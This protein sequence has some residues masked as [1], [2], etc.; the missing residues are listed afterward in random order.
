MSLE[1]RRVEEIKHELGAS[2]ICAYLGDAVLLPPS[3]PEE[4]LKAVQQRLM[5]KGIV[6]SLKPLTMDLPTFMAEPAGLQFGVVS[7]SRK[8]GMQ[9][10][11]AWLK[12]HEMLYGPKASGRNHVS[13]ATVASSKID[14]ALVDRQ[15]GTAGQR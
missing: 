8:C 3:V 10:G 14:I 7:P 15:F 13:C 12:A 1:R 11:A 4:V 2:K 9:Y 5:V 6:V